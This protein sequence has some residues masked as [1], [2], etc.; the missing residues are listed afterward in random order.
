[1][2]RRPTVVGT[3]DQGFFLMVDPLAQIDGDIIL[4]PVDVLLSNRFLCRPECLERLRP[5]AGCLV[6]ADLGDVERGCVDRE[7]RDDEKNECR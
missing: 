1:M 6:V 3:K 7:N 5:N 4:E 2:G